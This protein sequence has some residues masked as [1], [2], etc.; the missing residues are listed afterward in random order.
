MKSSIVPFALMLLS[1]CTALAER[2]ERELPLVDVACPNG[3][4]AVRRVPVYNG[5]IA[6]DAKLR[7]R[8]ERHEVVLGG[9]TGSASTALVCSQCG[10]QLEEDGFLSGTMNRWKRTATDPKSFQPPITPELR[11]FEAMFLQKEYLSYTQEVGL[12]G[13][14]N[15]QIAFFSRD[16][17]AKLQALLDE[18]TK[19]YDMKPLLVGSQVG[20]NFQWHSP[21][22]LV[23]LTDLKNGGTNSAMIM[24]IHTTRR[25]T[26][27]AEGP[28]ITDRV[29]A[30][31]APAAVA[32]H[33]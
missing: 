2:P 27:P 33:P 29:D 19:E 30:P 17:V 5:L 11:R 24:V 23:V 18:R 14:A 6:I 7:Q 26:Q 16:D 10:F 9:C 13:R 22:W 4:H 28:S 20:K 31:F 15:E 12:D 1:G 32:V 8:V 3:H 25:A 21:D